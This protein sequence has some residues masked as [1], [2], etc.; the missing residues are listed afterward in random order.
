MAR[1]MLL[2]WQGWAVTSCCLAG[3]R[4]SHWMEICLK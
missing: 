3:S 4:H 2:G 1:G